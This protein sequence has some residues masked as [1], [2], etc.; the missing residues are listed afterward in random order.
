MSGGARNKKMRHKK[1]QGYAKECSE[2][3]GNTVCV[4]SSGPKSR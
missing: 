4:E 3:P 2:S 1:G